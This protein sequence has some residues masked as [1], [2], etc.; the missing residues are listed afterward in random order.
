MYAAQVLAEHAAAL[1]RRPLPA[2]AHAAAIACVTDLLGCAAAGFSA[3]LAERVRRVAPRL[4]AAGN[5]SVWF[6]NTRLNAAGAVFCNSAAACA[7]DLDDGSRAARGHPGAAVIPAAFAVAAE[8]NATAAQL[9]A[10]I[11][12]GYEIG[13]RV[14]AARDAAPNTVSRQSGRWAGYAAAA[15]AGLLRS[16]SPDVLAHAFAIAGVTAPNQEANGSSGYSKLT[17]NDVKEG[18]AWSAAN[19]IAAVHLAE[20][21]LMGPLDILDHEAHFARGPLL[22]GLDEAEAPRAIE[23]TY[24]KLYACCR[25]NHCAIDALLAVMTQHRLRAV[26][27]EAVDV[28]TFG[29]ALQLGNKTAPA[30]LID[31]QYSVPYCMAIA[32]LDGPGALA[33]PGESVLYRADL[34][35]FA[36]KV[37]LYRDA[38]LDARFPAQTLARVTVR[39]RAGVMESSVTGP[40]GEPPRAL[41]AETLR[42]KFLAVT[43]GAMIAARRQ[44]LLAAIES[45]T[46]GDVV[47]LWCALADEI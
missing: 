3:P 26:D 7:L 37:T 34:S 33:P 6:G 9:L 24:F 39:T 14:A 44:S 18:I 29:W 43:G 31:V 23:Q 45:F 16:T 20:A 2:S 46:N 32:A 28:H 10:A 1:G 22:D 27:I 12:A 11:A 38:A 13:V 41:S 30:N 15:A 21:G 8:T 19:G 40:R 47:P 35:A 42:D 4:F 25:Y 17:G 5:A 36:R